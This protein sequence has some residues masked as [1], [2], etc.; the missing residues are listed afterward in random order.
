MKIL[1]ADSVS[2]H[3]VEILREQ[4]SWNVVFL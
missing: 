3:A 2:E 4:E 1:V